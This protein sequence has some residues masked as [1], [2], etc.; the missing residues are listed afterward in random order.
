MGEAI[1]FDDDM[2]QEVNEVE[3]VPEQ[4]DG[5]EEQIEESSEKVEETPDEPA[6][7]GVVTFT[8]EQQKFINEKIIARKVKQQREAERRAQE[9]E[10]QLQQIQSQ[11]PQKQEEGP[12]IPPMPDIWDSDYEKKVQER[13]QA[14]LS[15]AQWDQD[16][17]FRQEQ[18]QRLLYQQQQEFQQQLTTRVG[19]YTERAEKMGISRED[20]AVAGNA[21]GQFGVAPDVSEYILDHENGPAITM[22][23]AKNLHE[24]QNLQSMPPIKAA[25]YVEK[26]IAP[27]VA[28]GIKRQIP[29]P[30]EGVKGS[31]VPEKQR[32]PKGATF[33]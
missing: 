33:E 29:D 5:A 31:G 4:E 27:N 28:R 14:I 18:E 1:S 21:V 9:L 8:D 7:E 24:L 17:R 22:Y 32:G 13:D 6:E 15:K 10:E 12:T 11:L 19:S 3:N 26:K 2:P 20:L 23:L 25:V 16:Q 30:V